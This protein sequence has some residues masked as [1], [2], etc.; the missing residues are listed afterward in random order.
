MDED[1]ER[2]RKAL[3]KTGNKVSVSEPIMNATLRYEADV[4]LPTLA[5]EVGLKPAEMLRRLQFAGPG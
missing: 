1:S 3:A 2:F 5:A 4:D